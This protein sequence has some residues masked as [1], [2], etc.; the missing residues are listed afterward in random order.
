MRRRD[1]GLGALAMGSAA[2]FSARAQTPQP[3]PQPAAPPA[4]PAT[5]DQLMASLREQSKAAALA[6]LALNRDEVLW[7]GVAGVRR[8]DQPDLATLSDRWHLG[9]NTKAMTAAVYARLVEKGQAKWGATVPELF[10]DLRPNPA[11]SAITV[12]QLMGHVGGLSDKT[13]LDVPWLIAARGDPRPLRDQRRALA[14]KA[15]ASPP[16]GKPGVFEYANADFILLG[17]AIER[18]A[19]APWE[20]VIKAEVFDPL[21]LSTA[22]FGAP[23]GEAPWGHARD[24]HPLDPTGVSD[25]PPA[26]GPAG[27]VHMALADYAK[28]L[29]VFMS[30]GKGL[31]SADSVRHLT[32]PPTDEVRSYA[33]G[34]ITFKASPWTGKPGLAHEGSNTWWHMVALV[35]PASGVAVVTA[36]NDDAR[37]AKAAQALALGLTKRFDS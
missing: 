27:T 29:R 30:D 20:D 12:E 26:L 6:G 18:I 28:F 1:F 32:T 14:A 36:T 37:G 5:P 7:Q 19:D 23:L 17:A 33:G 35:S 11:W 3:T 25:N 34:W 9:S 8:T 31:L 2:G 24:G 22:G 16:A 10:P 4:A 15:F 21:E 13:L